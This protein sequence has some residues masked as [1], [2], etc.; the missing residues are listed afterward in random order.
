LSAAALSVIDECVA[1]GERVESRQQV[2]VV[3]ARAAVQHHRGAAGAG[4]ALEDLHAADRAGGRFG[5]RRTASASDGL[6]RLLRDGEGIGDIAVDVDL[7][8]IAARADEDDQ[9]GAAPDCAR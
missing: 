9:L 2:V 4:A 8:Q 5:H 3:R 7:A 1:G 6:H